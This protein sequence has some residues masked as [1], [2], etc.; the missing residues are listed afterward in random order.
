MDKQIP[1]NY[2]ITRIDIDREKRPTHGYE[3]RIR[4]RNVNIHKFFRDTS[5]KNKNAALEEACRYRDKVLK[6]NPPL[7]RAEFS[8]I[9][10]KITNSGIVGVTLI[11][12][13]DRRKKKTY[14][15]DY[16]KAWWSPKPGIHKAKMFSVNKYGYDE[17][18]RLAMKTREEG[19]KQMQ[20]YEV[21]FINLSK[22][23]RIITKKKYK[24]L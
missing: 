15:Y 5:Y 18:L 11:T 12:A 3:V 16:W 10:R 24:K 4:K 21:S 9:P 1:P 23:R 19:L 22:Q 13:I 17:A 14:Y 2:G 6:E 7:T 8:N 20:D